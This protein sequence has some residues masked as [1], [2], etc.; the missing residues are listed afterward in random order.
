MNKSSP[1]P[2]GTLVRL[3]NDPGRQGVLTGKLR[4]QAGIRKYQVAF[5]EGK[6]FQP[7]Y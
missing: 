3:R 2:A 6:T 5:P 1:L 4:E 7:D